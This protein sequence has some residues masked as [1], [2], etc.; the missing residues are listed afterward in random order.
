MLSVDDRVPVEDIRTEFGRALRG[1]TFCDGKVESV[2]VAERTDR[3]LEVRLL[4]RAATSPDA[5]EL[6]CLVRERLIGYL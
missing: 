2:R 5:W 3:A 1:S 4:M 6:R